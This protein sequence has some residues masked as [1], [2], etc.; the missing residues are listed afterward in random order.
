MLAG[1]SHAPTTTI[2]QTLK[3]KLPSIRTETLSRRRKRLKKGNWKF[4]YL[5][6]KGKNKRKRILAIA[7][8][9][10]LL[11]N[12]KT[13]EQ[14]K[15]ANAIILFSLFPEIF[16]I[17]LIDLQKAFHSISH[18]ILL[19]RL[20]QIKFSDQSYQWFKS[21]LQQHVFCGYFEL[22][23]KFWRQFLWNYRGSH[24]RRSIKRHF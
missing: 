24:Q 1:W 20:K 3:E 2:H 14:K 8:H 4:F 22:S 13:L 6:L 11:A 17:I 19:K 15:R 23:F 5:T 7:K 21:C 18:T 12:T 16:G 9:F 10:A